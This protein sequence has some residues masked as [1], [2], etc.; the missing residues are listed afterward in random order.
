M[1]TLFEDRHLTNNSSLPISI[2]IGGA[3]FDLQKNIKRQIYRAEGIQTLTVTNRMIG[4]NKPLEIPIKV[5]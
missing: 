5:T 1:N 3:T 4:M 2:T